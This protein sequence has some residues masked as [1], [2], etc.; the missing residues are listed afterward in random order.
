MHYILYCE[1]CIFLL[2]HAIIPCPAA[3]IM[4][5]LHCY[6]YI[7]KKYIYSCTYS[8]LLYCVIMPIQEAL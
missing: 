7:L 2:L 6:P 1:F 3:Y 8:V 4:F 5:L